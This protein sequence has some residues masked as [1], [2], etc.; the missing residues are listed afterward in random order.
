MKDEIVQYMVAEGA[1]NNRER[2]QDPN[3]NYWGSS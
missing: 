1:V 3:P 2:V